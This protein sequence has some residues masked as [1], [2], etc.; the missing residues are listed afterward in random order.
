MSY[1]IYTTEG[2][3]LSSSLAGESNRFY[4]IY[5]KDMGLIGVWGQGV[6]KLESKLSFHLQDLSHVRIQMIRGKHLWRLTDV[7]N[8]SYFENILASRSKRIVVGQIAVLLKRLLEEGKEP[9][10]YNLF[11]ESMKELEQT[12]LDQT[13]LQSFELLFVLRTLYHLGYGKNS[14]PSDLVESNGWG[15]EV[16]E[17]VSKNK[18]VLTKIAN[19]SLQHTHM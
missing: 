8:I 4:H 7:E 3:I 13:A 9:I 14:V 16:L 6:R 11:I 19:T 5:T 18:V 17:Q 15:K 1:H 2:V 12:E 10:L